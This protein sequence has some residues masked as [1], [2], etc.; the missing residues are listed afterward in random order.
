MQRLDKLFFK[1]LLLVLS[2]KF[3]IDPISCRHDC[4]PSTSVPD[5]HEHTGCIYI[6]CALPSCLFLTLCLHSS[7]VAAY[8]IILVIDFSIDFN[9]KPENFLFKI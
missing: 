3:T 2:I 5:R 9:V 1:K 8:G 7:C 4:T 6:H